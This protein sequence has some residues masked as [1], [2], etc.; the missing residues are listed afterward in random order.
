VNQYYRLLD[1]PLRRDN[2][3]LVDH[4]HAPFV[5]GA[6]FPEFSISKT[7]VKEGARVIHHH[8]GGNLLK[9]GS[10]AEHSAEYQ[11][12]ILYHF[13]H[14]QGVAQATGIQLLSEK[15]VAQLRRW[16]QFSVRAAKPNGWLPAIG[17]SNGRPIV[18]LLGSL[19]GPVMSPE[20]ASAAKALGIPPAR[21]VML[22]MGEIGVRMKNIKPG[23]PGFIGLSAYYLDKNKK[24]TGVCKEPTTVQYPDGG[25]T[26][27]RSEWS[28]EADYLSVSHYPPNIPGTHSHWDP[29]SII[30]H[31]KGRTLIGEPASNLYE[32]K[33]FS[34]HGG[35]HPTP[36]PGGWPKPTLH[37]GYSYGVQSH[38]CLVMNDDFLKNLEAMNHG[39]F[40]GGYPPE[41]HCGVFS[42]GGAIEVAEI[43]NDANGPTRHRRFVVHVR[44]VGFAFVDI[45][46]SS[47]PRLAPNQY[48]QYFHLEGDVEISSEAPE[49]GSAVR[50]FDGDASCLIVPGADIE[51][52]WRAYRDEYLDNLYRVPTT[53]GLPWVL[54]LTRRIRGTGVFATFL[55]TH[56]SAD[57]AL[58]AEYLGKKPAAYFD[59]QHDNVSINRVNLG[60]AGTL[61][62]ASCPFGTSAQSD[63]ISTD[64]QLA[65]ALLNPAGKMKAW[66]MAGGTSLAIGGKKIYKGK[67]KEWVQG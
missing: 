25:Y 57:V 64:G 22:S 54:E 62:L 3:H 43:W 33:R 20:I 4:G 19:A 26:F 24:T 11:Y 1:N 66:G 59:W 7:L 17:D 61:L 53:K 51:T 56:G 16:V 47:K 12:H 42:A 5:V 65:V 37:R 10:Y 8:F 34:G 36:P 35:E 32:D 45:V 40:W 55:L 21:N 41:H 31:T 52:R 15:Q 28:P 44:N 18:H 6:V 29:M 50:V 48:S 14:P 27:F 2:H 46:K 49:H 9:D 23:K 39:T 13:L 60:K 30:L 38:N 58:K 67:R 63:S